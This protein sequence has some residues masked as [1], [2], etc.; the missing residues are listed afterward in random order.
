MISFK[1]SLFKFRIAFSLLPFCLILSSCCTVSRGT[2]ENV[3]INSV[4]SGATIIV[5]EQYCGETPQ[6]VSLTR[7]HQHYIT[8]AKE[9]YQ[10]EHYL[11][12]PKADGGLIGN[13]GYLGGGTVFGL[14]VGAVICVIAGGAGGYA[15]PILLF[16]SGAGAAIGAVMTAGGTGVDLISGGGYALSSD[17]V[18]AQLRPVQ[19]PFLPDYQH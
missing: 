13:L 3:V 8:L 7:K 5:D 2:R 4:P 11:L 18:Q 10:P 15:A 12:K 16:C 1:L 17:Q 14:G 6:I 19:I 9:G